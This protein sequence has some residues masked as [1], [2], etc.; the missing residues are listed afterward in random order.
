MNFSQTFESLSL[1]SLHNL[2]LSRKEDGWRYVQTLAVNNDDG[3]DL[4]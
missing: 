3:V 2:A 4:I 1:D